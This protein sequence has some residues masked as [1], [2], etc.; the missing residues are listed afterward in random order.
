MLISG[1]VFVPLHAQEPIDVRLQKQHQ[2]HLDSMRGRFQSLRNPY[3]IVPKGVVV[4]EVAASDRAIRYQHSWKRD[5]PLSLF[6]VGQ[7]LEDDT[8]RTSSAWDPNWLQNFGGVDDP[9][10]RNGYFP[11]GVDPQMNPFYVALPYD[12]IMPGGG[13]FK[14]EASEL[15]KWFWAK[16]K[17]PGRTVCKDRWLAIHFGHKVCYAQWQDVGPFYS[18]D[19][20]YVFQHSRPK[21]NRNGHTGMSVSPAVLDFLDVQEGTKISWKFVEAVDVPHGPWIGWVL[22]E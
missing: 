3:R 2:K 6:W 7:P 13:M 20:A 11:E 21:Q 18:D 8:Q 17:V 14:P 10:R 22:P 15:I 4:D 12:D 1:L 19:S 9:K 5:I 16:A